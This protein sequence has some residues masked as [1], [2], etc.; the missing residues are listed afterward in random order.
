MALYVVDIARYLS[1]IFV[2]DLKSGIGPVLVYIFNEDLYDTS[3]FSI[4]IPVV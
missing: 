2:F 3:K 4:G 1:L